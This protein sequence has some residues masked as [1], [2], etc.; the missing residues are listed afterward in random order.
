[1]YPASRGLLEY[2]DHVMAEVHVGDFG[3]RVFKSTWNDGQFLGLKTLAEYDSADAFIQW[4]EVN[5]KVIN[6]GEYNGPW[7]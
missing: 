5:G 7:D 6:R 4:L 3:V 1:M 2:P